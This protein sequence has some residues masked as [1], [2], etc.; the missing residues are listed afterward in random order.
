NPAIWS[1]C[2]YADIID[3]NNENY[4][5]HPFPQKSGLRHAY[6]FW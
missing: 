4:I 6:S 1:W 5:Q 3:A 2:G